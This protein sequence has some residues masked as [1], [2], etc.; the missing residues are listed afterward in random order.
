MA[1]NPALPLLSRVQ[2]M[3]IRR[4][5]YVT[6]TALGPLGPLLA[7]EGVEDIHIHGPRAATWSTAATASRCLSGSRARRS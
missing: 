5:L 3:E 7:I 6:H 1:G 2:L 4:Q